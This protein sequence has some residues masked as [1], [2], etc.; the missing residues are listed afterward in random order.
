M[1]T[2]DTNVQIF[3]QY[4]IS[5]TLQF[6]LLFLAL[7]S[8][9]CFYQNHIIGFQIFVFRDFYFHV[10]LLVICYVTFPDTFALVYSLDSKISLE[11]NHRIC[12]VLHQS[13]ICN[14]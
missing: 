1:A 6:V 12:F 7:V 4:L 3:N 14:D 9:H 11:S 8:F 10:R 5:P 13:F 2:C